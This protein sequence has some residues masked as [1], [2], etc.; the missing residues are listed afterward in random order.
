MT[1]ADLTNTA[2]YDENTTTMSA[3]SNESEVVL[4]LAERGP[5]A[6]TGSKRI[7]HFLLM[8]SFQLSD[9]TYMLQRAKGP[10]DFVLTLPGGPTSSVT[11]Q[12][13]YSFAHAAPANTIGEHVVRDVSH[14]FVLR[15]ATGS[16]TPL[17][18]LDI[19]NVGAIL[20]GG[21]PRTNMN[22]TVGTG[23]A[24]VGLATGATTKPVGD[25]A[26]FVARQLLDLAILRHEQC[27]ITLEDYAV[28]HTAVLPCGHLFAAAALEE[29]FKKDA[30]V[31][32]ACRTRGRPTYV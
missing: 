28:G 2:M 25:L 10:Q 9:G 32:P 14:M 18:V 13:T 6:P 4:Y 5:V 7:N 27:P 23:E 29:S 17:T 16:Q 1:W 31:C 24:T 11:V 12:G 19:E 15:R 22:V 20:G 21:V 26:P 8:K 3:T 30:G